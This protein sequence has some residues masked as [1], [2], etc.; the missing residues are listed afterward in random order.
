MFFQNRKRGRPLVCSNTCI[1]LL[2]MLRHVFKLALRQL[3]GF[4][5]FLFSFLKIHLQVP[6]F[7][8]LSRRMTKTLS[9]IAYLSP[10]NPI[11]SAS[12]RNSRGFS[13]Y[14]REARLENICYLILNFLSMVPSFHIVFV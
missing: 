8:R 10:K 12:V 5:K 2:V 3:E 4:I 1:E 14:S 9:P 11:S 6:E 7:S 13:V